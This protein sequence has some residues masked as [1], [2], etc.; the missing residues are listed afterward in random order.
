MISRVQPESPYR[1]L[2]CFAR[3]YGKMTDTVR[4]LVNSFEIHCIIRRTLPAMFP[5]KFA[6]TLYGRI[7][8]FWQFSDRVF[9][10][11]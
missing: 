4:T 3:A 2:S 10:V 8:S 5:G 7:W 9:V 11:F 6:I 1:D